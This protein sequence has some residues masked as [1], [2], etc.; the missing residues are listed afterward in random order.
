MK[1]SEAI[2]LI[3][4]SKNIYVYVIYSRHIGAYTKAVKK[5]II[6]YIS[7]L[8]SYDELTISIMDGDVYI[9]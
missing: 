3:K 7:N 1:Q 5:D 2:K 9:G 8:N 4:N 6:N